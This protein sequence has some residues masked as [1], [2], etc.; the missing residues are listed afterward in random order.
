MDGGG[1]CRARTV[2]GI[3]VSGS[4][5][6]V[7]STGSPF[8]FKYT[9]PGAPFFGPDTFNITPAGTGDN[10]SGAAVTN[11]AQPVTVNVLAANASTAAIPRRVA[12]GPT[13]ITASLAPGT[14]FAGIAS[15]L[16]SSGTSFGIGQTSAMI[17][18]GSSNLATTIS[19]AWRGR[20][21]SELPVNSS[22]ANGKSALVQRRG[23]PHRHPH[24]QHGLGLRLA[25]VL[26]LGG[27]WHTR[28]DIAS[29]A[30][31]G[32]LYLGF[33]D[34]NDGKWYN[35]VSRQRLRLALQRHVRA[36]LAVG[37]LV[38]S[39]STNFGNGGT[40]TYRDYQGSW[41]AVHGRSSAA[42]S[43][44]AP[45][46]GSWGVDTV[47][48]VA[49]AVVDHDAEFAVVPEPGTLALLAAGVAALGLAYRRRKAAKA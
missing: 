30:S 38:Q 20:A 7:N 25:D 46:L 8:S 19:M 17:V 16:G 21:S 6:A 34:T 49:W 44:L 29:A 10:G 22:A 39:N 11:G 15:T 32:F 36:T 37:S 14:S 33:R 42:A 13:W 40:S 1:R 41:L 24:R 31:G 35:A 3:T 43:T 48:N 23:E 27:G 12:Y 9:A 2:T 45:L 5:L 28:P 47:N 26:R 4:S 18:A